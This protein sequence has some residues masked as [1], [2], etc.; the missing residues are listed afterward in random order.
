MVHYWV[1][2]A[3]CTWS[4]F[5]MLTDFSMLAHFPRKPWLV[6][7]QSS[8]WSPT[9]PRTSM[10]GACRATSLSSTHRRNWHQQKQATQKAHKLNPVEYFSRRLQVNGEISTWGALLVIKIG[11]S[12][13]FSFLWCW[14][15]E[16]REEAHEEGYE[17]VH[18][19][20]VLFT[21]KQKPRKL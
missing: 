8:P 7:S 13:F 5:P 11:D 10:A 12:V 19:E 21:K 6:L 2:H 4:S 16:A 3:K 9:R 17:N 1:R 15:W 20:E 14:T 18:H